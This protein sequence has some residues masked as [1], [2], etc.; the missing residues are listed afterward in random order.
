[1]DAEVVTALIGAL[2]SLV[3]AGI[4]FVAARR[5]LQE[6]TAR[7]TESP[8][9]RVAHLT[10]ALEEAV[11]VI[12]EFQTEIVRGQSTAER[13]QQDIERYEEIARLRRD[14]VEAVARVLRTEL[15]QE[16]GRSLRRDLVMNGAF[17]LLGAGLSLLLTSLTSIG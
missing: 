10:R 17:V 4:A 16:S 1:M 3:G 13:L 12:E 2:G 6:A 8:R 11:D 15:E 7:R 14:D 9:D 5:N